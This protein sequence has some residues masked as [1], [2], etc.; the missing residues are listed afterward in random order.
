MARVQPSG[1][2]EKDPMRYMY[3]IACLLFLGGVIVGLM[4]ATGAFRKKAITY[5][6]AP[7]FAPTHAPAFNA[8]DDEGSRMLL[9][10][11]RG[12]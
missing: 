12:A 10:A 1:Y 8:T 2:Q 3:C 5:V 11:L 6:R 4:F 9:A 7:T